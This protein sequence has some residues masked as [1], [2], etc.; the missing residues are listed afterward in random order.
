MC[1]FFE[2]GAK[3]VSY[4]FRSTQ[5]LRVFGGFNGFNPYEKNI[6]VVKLDHFTSTYGWIET[7]TNFWEEPFFFHLQEV[8]RCLIGNLR[9]PYLPKNTSPKVRFQKEKKGRNLTIHHELSNFSSQHLAMPVS[10][11][12]L[13]LSCMSWLTMTN[14]EVCNF[15]EFRRNDGLPH[16]VLGSWKTTKSS[17][18]GH[19]HQ[20]EWFV[21]CSR[22][23]WPEFISRLDLLMTL[24]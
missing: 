21:E 20:I 13:V 5:M 18:I 17:Q 10:Y 9:A 15:R 2:I 24:G 4:S 1:F 19:G 3:L 12:D 6:A 11:H 22:C 16:L 8:C 23:G 7:T 14:K